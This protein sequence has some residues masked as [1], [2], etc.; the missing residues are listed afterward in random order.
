MVI[1]SG[2]RS[3]GDKLHW[4]FL[5]PNRQHFNKNKIYFDSQTSGKEYNSKKKEPKFGGR[6]RIVY[7]I[8]CGK[9][10]VPLHIEFYI[11]HISFLVSFNI[12]AK[13]K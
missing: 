12:L 8:L 3:I 1:Q 5:C 4:H 7:V 11:L 10:R 9:D 6:I 13:L 2:C